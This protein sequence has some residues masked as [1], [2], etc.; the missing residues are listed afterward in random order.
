MLRRRRE[1]AKRT[2]EKRKGNENM[3]KR[4]PK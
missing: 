3:K 2:R 1:R 4:W